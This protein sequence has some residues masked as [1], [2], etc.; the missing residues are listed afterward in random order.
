MFDSLPDLDTLA[1]ADDATVA[2]AIEGWARAESA[3][4]ARRLAAIAELTLRR[5]T[6]FG[7]HRD[8]RSC[9]H[10]DSAAAEV[11]AALGLSHR[12]ASSQM[13]FAQSL[14]H[15]L[16]ATAKLLADGIISARTAATISWRTALVEDDAA[17]D[18]IDGA[19]ANE[20]AN[21][22][23]LSDTL[24][25]LA[26]DE[27]LE[28]HDPDARRQFHAANQNRDIQF[29]KPDDSTGTVSIRGRLRATDAQLLEHRMADMMTGIC[30]DDP[31]TVGQC[32]SD[33]LGALPNGTDRMAC[34]CGNV[35]CAA[36]GRDTRGAAVVVHVIAEQATVD[37]AKKAAKKPTFKA[38][39]VVGGGVVPTPLLA[40]LIANGAKVAPMKPPC[41]T[42]QN[43]YRPT[44]ALAYF[45]RARD[46][47]CR[48]PGCNRSAQHIDID[49]A[50]AYPAGATH[51]S[52][53]R[54]LCRKH[55]LLKTFWTQWSDKQYPDGRIEWTSPTGRMY[56]TYPGCR[57]ALPHWETDTGPPPA[58]PPTGPTGRPQA[59]RELMMPTR[60]RT[61]AADRAQRVKAERAL[62]A[63]GHNGP[64][65]ES[66]SSPDRAHPGVD[67]E[68]P[69]GQ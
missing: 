50:V 30:P 40:E 6:E 9:D 29:G 21:W 43:R 13:L 62:N 66:K 24:L 26:I 57:I 20:A 41:R 32:R 44:L 48:F 34:T 42:A 69:G 55:H 65:A 15:R 17:M 28:E 38:A 31:R 12:R 8:L 27:V 51:P 10:W 23:P 11:A 39:V 4:A 53:L 56:T 25:N 46:L 63:K 60:R 36:N 2:A 35:D 14:R 18:R 1:E 45:I 52:N 37:A 54:C 5:T 19:I 7:D 59:G 61:R 33:A 49:H 67:G 58:P 68:R 64:R 22:G 47:T 3:A 16:P